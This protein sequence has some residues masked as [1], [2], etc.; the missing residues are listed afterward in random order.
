MLNTGHRN[1]MLV[2]LVAASLGMIMAGVVRNY[3]GI[4]EL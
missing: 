4:I 2:G 1:A 3:S